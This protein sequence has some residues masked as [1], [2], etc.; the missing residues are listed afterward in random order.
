M[1]IFHWLFTIAVLIKDDE[2]SGTVNEWIDLAIYRFYMLKMIRKKANNK[3]REGNRKE[4]LLVTYSDRS[5][6]CDKTTQNND[7]NFKDS[8]SVLISL[9]LPAQST[10][11]RRQ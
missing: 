6:Y 4:G 10:Q 8:G 3:G 9:P 5:T 11:N 7:Y 1:A 2:R